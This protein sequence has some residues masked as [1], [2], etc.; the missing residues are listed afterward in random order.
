VDPFFSS[1]YA[2]FSRVY[3]FFVGSI[4][5]MG[6]FVQL[7]YQWIVNSFDSIKEFFLEI[8]DFF[9]ELPNVIEGFFSSFFGYRKGILEKIDPPEK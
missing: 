4:G 8:L 7:A 6:E 2:F 9:Q 5:W 1:I 3:D